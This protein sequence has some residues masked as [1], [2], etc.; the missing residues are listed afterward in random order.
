MTEEPGRPA[1][2]VARRPGDLDGL[3][4][5]DRELLRLREAIDEDPR[6]AV[7]L[8]APGAGKTA[9]LTAVA[10][11]AGD[12]G[13]RTVWLRGQISERGLAYARLVDLVTA[14]VGPQGPEAQALAST[15]LGQIV[16]DAATSPQPVEPLRL[17]L[18]VKEWLT[19]VAPPGGL[20]VVVDDAQW[21]DASSRAVLA[22]VANRV[23]GTSVSFAFSW[24][25][26]GAPDE[27]AGQPT[28]VLPPLEL[29]QARA[30]LRR[31]G[32]SL[33]PWVRVDIL[34]RAAGN[35]LALVEFA[36]ASA[37]A[38]S[39]G[40]T[41]SGPAV[42]PTVE[43][44]FAMELPTF[45]EETRRVLLM[46]AAGADDLRVLARL[47]GSRPLAAALEPAERTGLVQTVGRRV[48]FK[49]P[50]A[51][52]TVY[53][54]A[55]TAQRLDV[56]EQ[57]AEAYADDQERWVWHRAAAALGADEELA[58]ALAQ[59]AE[60][61]G[62]RGAHTEAAQT[63][64]RAAEL[65]DGTALRDGRLL[66]AMSYLRYAGYVE[67]LTSLAER[68]RA[69][70][71]DPYV[72]ALAGHH[73]AHALAQAL[74]QAAA[75]D[76]LE[77]AL[78][79]M[80]PFDDTYGWASLTTLASLAYQTRRNVDTVVM[81]LQRY[82][83]R[84]PTLPPPFDRIP[85]ACDAWV[86][87]AIAP[88]ARPPSLVRLVRE[89][90]PG[91]GQLPPEMV[92]AEE[93][94]LGATAWLLNEHDVA[95]RRLS[96]ALDLMVRGV[97]A[98][99]LI[100][101]VM[102]LGQV[103]FD[104][105]LYADVEG[106]GKLMVDIAEAESLAFYRAVGLELRARAAAVRGDSGWAQ[107]TADEVLRSLEVGEARSLEVNLR[108]DLYYVQL[109]LRDYP[110][111]YRQLRLLFDDDGAPVHPH[112]SYRVLAD[113]VSVAVRAGEVEAVRPIVASAERELSGSTDLWQR[114]ILCRARAVLGGADAEALFEA[115]I[116]DPRGAQWPLEWA[117]AHLDYGI[118][119]RRHRRTSEARHRLWTAHALFSRLEVPAWRALAEAELRAA[120]VGSGG[121]TLSGWSELTAQEREV[122]ELAATGKTNREIGAA[123]F[124][125][126]RTVSAHLYHA[127][128][129]LGVTGRAQLRDVVERLNQE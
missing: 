88:L 16:P 37:A 22:F 48:Q 14:V 126:P 24:R 9:L 10:G 116:E 3:V 104:V 27:L 28:I 8:G 55:T 119:L 79:E 60:R 85:A 66:E 59:T 50:L 67:H 98:L 90:P 5:R 109:N 30:L 25:G 63:M 128:P 71:D 70:T 115:A 17:R 106:S 129:K 110:A 125:S 77:R 89:T 54:S 34:R 83:D 26:E 127:F 113:L 102:G 111:G 75:Q 62:Q 95:L 103:Q 87:V 20:L 33:D 39:R 53:D 42:P 114:M 99:L 100:Q 91:D 45:G 80:L 15:I 19:R 72:R 1:E 124:L 21:V 73:V 38:R 11:T 101:T 4:G 69:E 117:N 44:S 76:A 12:E 94:M 36:R 108:I 40:E 7:V 78:E 18:D 82:E 31:C 105:G 46:A 64:V 41:G 61:A 47:L 68:V 6:V 35:P 121:D 29:D 58:T 92:A 97:S 84:A 107:E 57:L 96:K 93:M 123:L 2:P 65:S 81:W 13:W 32:S 43:S 86:R 49:H 52:S 74:G 118:W 23:A 51:R 122:V 56:H 120:G 112:V